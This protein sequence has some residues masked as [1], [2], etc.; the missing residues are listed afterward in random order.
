M[1]GRNAAK[2]SVASLV[3]AVR[4]D[5]VGRQAPRQTRESLPSEAGYRLI[6]LLANRAFSAQIDQSSMTLQIIDVN[7]YAMPEDCSNESPS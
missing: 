4:A 2:E 6:Q 3:Q 7:G 1:G 5:E